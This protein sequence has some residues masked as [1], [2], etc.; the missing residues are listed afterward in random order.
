MNVVNVK[1]ASAKETPHNVDVR[2]LANTPETQIVH[3]TLKSGEALKLHSTPVLAHF[4]VLEGEPTMEIGNEQE[5]CGVG[6]LIE[7]PA[8]IPHRI[9]NETEQNARIMVI[10]TPR[11]TEESRLL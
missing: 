8:R 5:R 9:L 10:K 1:E 3:I 2:P 4:F 6:T 11:Q 7:S